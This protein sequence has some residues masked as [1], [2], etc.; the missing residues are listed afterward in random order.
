VSDPPRTVADW[1]DAQA[2]RLEGSGTNAQ[3]YAANTVRACARELRDLGDA[4]M[5]DPLAKLRAVPRFGSVGEYDYYLGDRHITPEEA[6]AVVR[7]K[8]GG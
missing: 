6:A 3:D 2:R 4:P 5:P 1:L 8:G 7:A